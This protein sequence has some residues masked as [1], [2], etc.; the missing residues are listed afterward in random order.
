MK[1]RPI[2]RTERTVLP[3]GLWEECTYDENNN[4]VTY[5]NGNNYK[6]VG[7]YDGRGNRLTY[8]NSYGYKS[9]STYDEDNNMLT[10]EDSNGN[11]R[12]FKSCL[13]IKTPPYFVNNKRK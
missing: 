10:F 2:N 5:E 12:Q 11:K 1:E 8:E 13:H 4:M 6:A 3:C 7:T 9:V